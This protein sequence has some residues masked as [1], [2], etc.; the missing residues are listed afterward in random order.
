MPADPAEWPRILRG[1]R[2]IGKYAGMS[3]RSTRRATSD[4]DHPF[5]EVVR[6]D[7]ASQRVWCWSA[8]LWSAL[9]KMPLAGPEMTPPDAGAPDPDSILL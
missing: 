5:H 7:P 4:P 1:W 8:E 6:R 9:A 2:V 3:S